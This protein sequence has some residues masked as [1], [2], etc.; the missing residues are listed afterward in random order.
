MD[1]SK[2]NLRITII[3]YLD[4]TEKELKEE[5]LIKGTNCSRKVCQKL[6]KIECDNIIK[7]GTT[8]DK[9][10]LNSKNELNILSFISKYTRSTSFNYNIIL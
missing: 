5:N 2:S 6:R 10:G 7:T 4:T 1:K 3:H 9:Y 8:S